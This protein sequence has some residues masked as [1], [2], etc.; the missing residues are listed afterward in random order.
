MFLFTLEIINTYTK[1]ISEYLEFSVHIPS[2]ILY[3]Q[4]IWNEVKKSN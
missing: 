4:I 3:G 1:N 2:Q